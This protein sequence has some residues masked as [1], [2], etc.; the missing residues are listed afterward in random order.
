MHYFYNVIHLPQVSVKEKKNWRTSITIICLLHLLKVLKFGFIKILRGLGEIFVD[1]TDQQACRTE[2][3][4]FSFYYLSY[5]VKQKTKTGSMIIAKK[6][7]K[8]KNN[9]E[10]VRYRI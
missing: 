8:T 2:Y 10:T 1:K 9:E 4:F 6:K 7:K 3:F 5:L